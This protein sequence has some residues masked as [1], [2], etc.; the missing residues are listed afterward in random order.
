[1]RPRRNH[2]FAYLK[3]LETVAELLAFLGAH[4]T[5]LRLEETAVVGATRARANRLTNADH[6]NIRRASRAAGDQLRAIER[7]RSDGRLEM[8]APELRE[9][10]ALRTRHRTLSLREL[11]LRC[12]PPATKASAQRRLGRLRRLAEH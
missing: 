1:V 2:A 3:G 12:S 4:E 10:A 8:L 11:A 7:L 6:A 9:I 5:A